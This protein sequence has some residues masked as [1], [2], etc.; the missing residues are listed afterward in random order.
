MDSPVGWS[1]PLTVSTIM[2]DCLYNNEERDV[3]TNTGCKVRNII[4]QIRT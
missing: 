4:P 1:I 2:Q 3:W